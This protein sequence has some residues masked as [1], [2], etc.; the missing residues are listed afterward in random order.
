MVTVFLSVLRDVEKILLSV[1][2]I[3]SFAG[4]WTEKTFLGNTNS[5]ES[6]LL[7]W[8]IFEEKFYSRSGI[9]C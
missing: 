3:L 1:A 7:L 6:H 5:P 4:I 2:S 9:S 8:D